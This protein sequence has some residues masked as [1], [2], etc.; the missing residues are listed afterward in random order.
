MQRVAPAMFARHASGHRRNLPSG[1][2]VAAGIVALLAAAPAF[3]AT[4]TWTGNAGNNS[5]NNSGNW[6]PVVQPAN[7]GTADI[8][9]GATPRLTPDLT[10]PW[11][12]NSLT[13]NNTAGGYTLISTLGNTLTIGAG[14]ITN[15]D[16]GDQLINQSMP[17]TLSAAQTWSAAAGNMLIFNPVNNG[18]HLLTVNATASVG[19]FANAVLSGSGGFTK[20]GL[21]DV[22]LQ[23]ANT[24][25]GTTTVNAGTLQV[26]GTTGVVTI[27]GALEIGDGVG[28]AIDTVLFVNVSNKIADSATVSVFSTG[29]WDLSYQNA[30]YSEAIT[31]LNIVSTGIAGGGIVKIN[32]GVLT[33]LGNMTMTGGAMTANDTFGTL[34]I[35]DNLITNGSDIAASISSRLDFNNGARTL[36]IDD[37]TALNDL[38]V[39]GVV[40]NGGIVKDGPGTLRLGAANTYAGGTT[41]NAG[42]ILLGH[43]SALGTG[44]LTGA[45]GTVRA[46]GAARTIANAVT[47]SLAVDGAFDLALSSLLHGEI[48]KNGPGTLVFGQA[49]AIIN[50][51]T[52]NAGAVRVDAAVTFAAGLTNS[53][54]LLLGTPTLTVNGAGFDNQSSLSLAGN[55]LAGSGP[56]VNSGLISGHG[57]ISAPLANA[58]GTLRVVGGTMNVTSAFSNSGVIRLDGGA[59]LVGGA[60]TNTGLIQGDGAIAN[61]LTN[62]AGGEL[63]ADP[64]KS[65]TFTGSGHSNAGQIRLLGGALDFQAALTNDA[66]AFIS[67]N[68]S[69]L[70]DGLTNHG[71]MNF[72]GTANIVGDVTNSATG[73]VISGGGGATIF[74]DDVINQGEIRTSTNGFTVFFGAVSG[75]GTFTGTG[76]VN[77]EGDLNPGNSPAAASFAGDV[78]FGPAAS[79][80]IELG[81]LMP[82]AQYDR[83]VVAGSVSLAG[84]LAVSLIDAGAGVFAPAAGD[85]F[86]ILD[87]GSLSGSFA[88]IQLPTL[89]GLQW[90]LSKLYTDGRLLVAPVF[91]ADFDEDGDVDKFDLPRWRTGFG[92]SGSAT[93]MQGDA[94]GDHDVDGDDFLIWQRQLGSG[95]PVFGAADVVPEPSTRVLLALVGPLVAGWKRRSRSLL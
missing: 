41:L 91:A 22:S 64:G 77:F 70:T 2:I 74:Y 3:A 68:G 17:I 6:S 52:V 9:F 7:N 65:L 15:N 55:T 58:G 31:N 82:S 1:L 47:G 62:A 28:A 67:G 10:L 93:H 80:G 23:A 95:P 14:G 84:T 32:G 83:L 49:G 8:I 73:K 79:V 60:I 54:T 76:T 37:G 35:N 38:N 42:T 18:G 44:P 89:T 16:A 81:G 72:A 57:T 51:L 45:G 75:G 43:D 33:V 19:F 78:G 71:T 59:G 56:V 39:M 69:L 27:P 48:T 90:D 40:V 66:G 11:N 61:P 20:N 29:F 87:W 46:D 24:Y 53:A 50:S 21:N 94:D 86:D 25:T 88:S 13:F 5:W 26:I 30:V 34:R 63:R 36:T 85:S 92:L 12:V 4:W